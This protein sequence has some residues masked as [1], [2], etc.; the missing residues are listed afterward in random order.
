MKASQVLAPIM[1]GALL[2]V[3]AGGLYIVDCRRAGGEL[4]KCWLTGLPIAGLGAGVGGGFK[5]GFE[6]INPALRRR[7]DSPDG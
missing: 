3:V 6:T 5:V 4:D 7:I 2:S 1:S